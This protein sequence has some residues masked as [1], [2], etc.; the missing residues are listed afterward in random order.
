MITVYFDGLCYPRNPGGVAAYGYAV[1]RDGKQIWQG[2]G[3]VG[4]GKG[5]TNNVAEYEGLMAAAQWLVD[6]GV[7][8]KILIKGDSE[9]VIKQMKGEYRVSSATSKKYVPEIKRL[10][11]GKDVSF[12]WVPREENEEADGLSRMGY[13]SYLRQKKR[14]KGG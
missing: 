5:M 9:L 3:G 14:K 8:D 6:E 11:Q 4:E 2:F 12:S 7:E 13:E 10:L 1:Y